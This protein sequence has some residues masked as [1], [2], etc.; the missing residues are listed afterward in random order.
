LP[1]LS[2][3]LALDLPSRLKAAD[4][5]HLLTDA[6]ALYR[7]RATPAGLRDMAQSYVG[8]DIHIFEA[9]R[10]RHIWQLGGAAQLGVDTALPAAPAE[11]MV[12]P[13]FTYASRALSGLRGDYYSGTNFEVL[14]QSKVDPTV[15]FN[16]GAD[17]P[18]KGTVPLEQL[19]AD[20]FSV[21]WSGQV[22]SLYS[23]TYSFRTTSDDGVRLSLGGRTLIDHWDDHPAA[24]DVGQFRMEAGRWYPIVLEYYEKAGAA[25][26]ELSWSSPSQRSEIIPEECLYPILDERAEIAPEIHGGCETLTIG[27]AVVGVDRP[28][29]AEDYGAPLADD[30]AHLF[31]V[32]VPAAQVPLAAQRA[33]LLD[34]IEA[35]KPAQ[36]DFRLC[37]V[38]PRM[39]VGV[40]ARLG[41]DS[42]VAGAGPPM[43]LGLAELG[44]DSYLG[45]ATATH[46][47]VADGHQAALLS[48]PIG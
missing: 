40:Q 23:E 10:E 11:G 44:T 42:I 19:G 8:A 7:R 27:H 2:T 25:R 31:T 29:A 39:R 32:V 38:E 20:Y 13:G 36:T 12:V 33:A 35:E 37:L 22:R 26:I 43:N 5:R 48:A 41:I 45:G 3:W 1:V 16:W 46:E 17:S 24:N 6:E 15:N 18:L 14:R 28:L 47:R 30:F 34:L 21:R 9:F 4:Q